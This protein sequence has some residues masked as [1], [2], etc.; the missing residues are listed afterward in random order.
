MSKFKE[1][2]AADIAATF[3]N[4]DD[5][6]EKVKVKYDGVRYNIPVVLDHNGERERK[7]YTTTDHVQG[8]FVCD[9]T[10]YIN[11]N[12]LPVVPR[13]DRKI[14]IEGDLYKIARSENEMGTIVLYLEML[15][16]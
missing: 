14:E 4:T 2:V 13:K 7:K 16:E 11:V 12:D 6:A 3:I 10:A 9:A 15:D 5:F 8:I 1:T